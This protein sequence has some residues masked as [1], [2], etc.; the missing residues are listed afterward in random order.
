MCYEQRSLCFG[1]HPQL[2]TGASHRVLVGVEE[3][4]FLRFVTLRTTA[5]N[6]PTVVKDK[7]NRSTQVALAFVVTL[8][9]AVG[10]FSATIQPPQ[11]TKK[12]T[13]TKVTESAH[14]QKRKT[15]LKHSRTQ[16]RT[17]V[18]RR[19]YYERF[20]ASSFIDGDQGLGDVTTGEDPVVR[21]AAIDALGNM[22]GTIVAIDPSSGR[23][24]AMVNQ[25]LA[26]SEGAQP[27]STFKVAVA[28]A[29]LNENVI[30]KETKV[31]LGGSY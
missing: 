31:S 6:G 25:K 1:A 15:A 20:T 8:V 11:R 24:L 4:A 27:C 18:A 9:L 10:G 3:R 13:T 7:M 12:K 30:T 29:A 17:R 26:L 28:L 22:N 16:T 5:T 19:R 21:E 14:A 2:R 23:I